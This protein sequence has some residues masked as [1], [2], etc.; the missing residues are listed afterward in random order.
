VQVHV[1][2][3]RCVGVNC[4]YIWGF[5]RNIGLFGACVG[6]C[7][8]KCRLLLP[9]GRG[10][11]RV[12]LGFSW[13]VGVNCRYNEQNECKRALY[14]RNIGLFCIRVVPQVMLKDGGLFCGYT[15]LFCGYTGLFCGRIGGSFADFKVT[16]VDTQVLFLGM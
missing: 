1:G 9:V 10:I 13:Y 3:C 4:G 5:V 11:L 12:Y 2:C 14:F 6:S 15:G 8:V 16:F 7:N